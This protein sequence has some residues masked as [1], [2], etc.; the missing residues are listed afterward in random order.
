MT[1][2]QVDNHLFRIGEG[3]KG[4]GLFATQEIPPRTLVHVA[5]CIRVDKHEY[6]VHVQYSIFEHYLFND[7]HGGHKLLALGYGSLFNHSSR[8]TNMDYRIDS[9]KLQIL[10][11]SGH[12]R[13]AKEEELCIYYGKD[14]WFDDESA[15]GSN[16]DTNEQSSSSDDEGFLDRIEIVDS[17]ADDDCANEDGNQPAENG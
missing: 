3:P 11:F 5:P 9:E 15:N 7:T 16:R 13:I 6:D 8:K 4:R 17:D 10:Y 2:D 14:L 1:L 12:K